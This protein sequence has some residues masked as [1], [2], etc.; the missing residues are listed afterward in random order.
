[1]KKNVYL[2]AAILMMGGLC[3]TACSDDEK[4]VEVEKIV[5]EKDYT[6]LSDVQ[7]EGLKG[8]PK[9]ITESTSTTHDINEIPD[10]WTSKVVVSYNNA[11]YK[12]GVDVYG[13]TFNKIFIETD[14]NYLGD[15]KLLQDT[16]SLLVKQTNTLAANNRPTKIVEMSYN[17]FYNVI[18]DDEGS[19]FQVTNP[20]HDSWE[21][22]YTYGVDS[23][24]V[25]GLKVMIGE[26]E[27]ITTID[28][29]A[30]K[31]TRII[32]GKSIYS[33]DFID[34]VKSVLNLDDFGWP[35]ENSCENFNPS[36]VYKLPTR[37]FETDP[38]IKYMEVLDEKGNWTV[39]YN[40]RNNSY[41]RRDIV[42]Y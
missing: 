39:R 41:V 25:K 4:I 18:I 5:I 26:T 9:T 27:S 6:K 24:L 8:N 12:T 35:N 2:G 13:A 15:F 19:S 30:K 40:T 38:S 7:R 29:T 3:W 16:M 21:N 31:A 10:K 17:F 22:T 14:P 32:R 1:M 37:A 28:T 20:I 23:V 11:G 33:D 34:E 42:Y 36:F